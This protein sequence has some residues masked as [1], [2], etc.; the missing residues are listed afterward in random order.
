MILFKYLSTFQYFNLLLRDVQWAVHRHFN[1]SNFYN[2]LAVGSGIGVRLNLSI[3]IFR[4]DGAFP[5][6]DPAK[7]YGSR[8]VINNA[9]DIEWYWN[10]SIFNFGIGYPF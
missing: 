10:N 7:P 2:E 9:N 5:I 4:L 8:W 6:H 1:I 3:F